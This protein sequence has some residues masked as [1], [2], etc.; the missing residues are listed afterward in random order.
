M[1]GFIGL[2]AAQ[3]FVRAGHI[4]YGQTRSEKSTGDLVKDE[5]IPVV[6]DPGS[7]EGVEAFV[8]L[9]KDVDVGESSYFVEGGLMVVIDTVPFTSPEGPLK[10]FN[11]FAKAVDSRPPGAKPSYIY[12]GG[13]W[14][15]SRGGGGLDKW[16]DERQP[17]AGRLQLT[18]WRSEVEKVV[19]TCES[20]LSILESS[21]GC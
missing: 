18:K 7:D 8:K 6:L 11:A 5:I 21:R 17:N 13:S 10:L 20:L 19:L 2:P 14:T 9:A 3:A 16:T 1:V 12:C 15:M 4:V